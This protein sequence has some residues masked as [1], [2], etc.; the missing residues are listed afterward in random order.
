MMKC[1]TSRIVHLISEYD[2]TGHAARPPHECCM[3]KGKLVILWCGFRG[4]G[5][6]LGFLPNPAVSPVL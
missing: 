6:S 2:P 3:G 1:N 4:V 5:C